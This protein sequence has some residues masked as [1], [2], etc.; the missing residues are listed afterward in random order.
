MVRGVDK[1]YGEGRGKIIWRGAW[2]KNMVR[3]VAKEYGEGHG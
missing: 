3:G 1:E 2:L